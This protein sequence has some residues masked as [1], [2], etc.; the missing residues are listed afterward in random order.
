MTL[1]TGTADFEKF[2]AGDGDDR[3]TGNL[4]GNQIV[5]ARGLDTIHGSNGNDQVTGDDGNDKIFG[6]RDNDTLSGGDGNDRVNGGTGTDLMAGNGGNDTFIFQLDFGSDTVQGF[7]DNL[8]TLKF[9]ANF[10]DGLSVSQF[11]ATY[12]TVVGTNTVF[13]FGDGEV[14]VVSGVTNTNIFLD[15]IAFL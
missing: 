1:A 8:D 6:D 2:Y 7:Q 4:L 10:A 11:I 14:L 9:N 13:D 3:I 15:D 5:G 12:A